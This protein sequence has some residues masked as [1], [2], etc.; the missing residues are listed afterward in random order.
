M[1]IG[2]EDEFKNVIL[3][4]GTQ[5]TDSHL[6]SCRTQTSLPYFLDNFSLLGVDILYRKYIT[7]VFMFYER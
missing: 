5:L 3:L 7:I 1:K 6:F 4:A 2:V